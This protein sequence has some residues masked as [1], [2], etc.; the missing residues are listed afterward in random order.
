MAG[1]EIVE[2]KTG[3]EFPQ[4]LQDAGDLFGIFHHQ[5]LGDFEFERTAGDRRAPQHR[6]Q[7]LNQV[8]PQQLARRHIDRREH[9]HRIA[10]RRA[11]TSRSWRAVRS[12]MNMP[13]S[14]ISPVSSAMVMNSAGERRPS[15]G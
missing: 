14:T 1:A 7:I 2:R 5:Q 3:A 4:A 13:R 9:R 6:A 10:Q 15:F 12:S 11:A 8:L